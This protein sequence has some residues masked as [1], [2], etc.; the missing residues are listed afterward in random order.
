LRQPSDF[1]DP[2]LSW[3]KPY[4]GDITAELN[5]ERND[6]RKDGAIGY[7]HPNGTHDDVFWSIALAVFATVQMEFEPFLAVIPR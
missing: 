7:P 5:V 2:L 1:L 4:R 3:E 6:L